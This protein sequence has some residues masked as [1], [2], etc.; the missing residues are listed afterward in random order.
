MKVSVIASVFHAA[1]T[2][3]LG[4]VLI[5]HL[6]GKEKTGF[7]N[8]GKLYHD[9][10]MTKSYK[11]EMDKEGGKVTAVV[12]S[13]KKEYGFAMEQSKR[14]PKFS[15]KAD[16]LK[17]QIERLETAYMQHVKAKS[18]EYNN[19]IIQQLNQYVQDYGKENKYSLIL[20]AEGSG[21][22]MYGDADLDITEKVTGYVNRKFNGNE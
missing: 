19:K 13:L 5:F 16:T 12:D 20:G 11:A 6:N 3:T 15:A 1:I 22:L 9:F 21:S 8:V 2:L 17:G 4:V 18:D 14:N 10:E 7:V